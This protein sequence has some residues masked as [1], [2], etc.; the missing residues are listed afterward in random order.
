MP[1]EQNDLLKLS[2]SRKSI[3]KPRR[4]AWNREDNR[5]KK[6]K[7]RMSL[8]IPLFIPSTEKRNGNVECS[9][10]FLR[11]EHRSSDEA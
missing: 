3:V 1:I 11:S 7:C 4:R 5:E 10:L 2:A 9:L 6:W 8:F